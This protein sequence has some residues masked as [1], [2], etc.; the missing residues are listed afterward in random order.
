MNNEEIRLNIGC[1]G[2]PLLNYI[3]IDMDS[4]DDLKERYPHQNFPQGIEVHDHDI[5][6]LPY[7]DNSVSEIKASAFIEHLNFKNE[8]KFFYEIKRI[9]RPD[10]TFEFSVPNFEKVVQTWLAAKD[11]WKDFYRDDDEAIAEKHWFGNY[12]Y[13]TNNRWGYLMAMIFGSQNG[14]GQSHLNAYTVPK[15]KAMMNKLEF[16]VVELS[17]FLWKEDRDPMIHVLVKK[18]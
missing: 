2:R 17:E 9:L 13:S 11:D 6:N 14:E 3:N 1:G 12:S 16:E 7:E 4:L 10:G 18:K 8:K 15:I 5:L